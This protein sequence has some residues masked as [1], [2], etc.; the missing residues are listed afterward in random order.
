MIHIDPKTMTPSEYIRFV[1]ARAEESQLCRFREGDAEAGLRTELVNG[2]PYAHIQDEER[3]RHF[4]R[5]SRHLAPDEVDQILVKDK[6][7]EKYYLDRIGKC[8][9]P[10]PEIP[11]TQG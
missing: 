9:F 3:Y 7:V 4:L 5:T 6:E 1:Q 11:I 10:V 8:I 2:I